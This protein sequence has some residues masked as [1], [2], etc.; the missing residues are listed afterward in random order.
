MSEEHEGENI[1]VIGRHHVL[2]LCQLQ[3]EVVELLGE[4]VDDFAV[5]TEV[6]RGVAVVDQ[7]GLEE[8]EG[9]SVAE[10]L[11]LLLVAALMNLIKSVPVGQRLAES[12]SV[13]EVQ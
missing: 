9:V 12:Q 8:L 1:G 4:L 2:L 5:R 7:L 3:L 13:L 6:L 10:E 11:P